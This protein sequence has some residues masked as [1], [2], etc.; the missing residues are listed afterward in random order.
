MLNR[1]S[2]I[3]KCLTAVVHGAE[4]HQLYFLKSALKGLR[5]ILNK[6]V[7]IAFVYLSGQV[8]PTFTMSI[9]QILVN[10]LA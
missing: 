4:S 6:C 10:L 2:E 3:K 5:I 7:T 8:C 1:K 9:R